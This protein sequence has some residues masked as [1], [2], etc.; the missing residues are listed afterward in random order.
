MRKFRVEELIGDKIF[1]NIIGEKSTK[2]DYEILD[3]KG[4]LDKLKKKFY[5]TFLNNMT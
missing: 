2:V 4:F 3:K 5:Q 1:D